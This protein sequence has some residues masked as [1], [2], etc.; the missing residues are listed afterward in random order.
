MYTI[1]SPTTIHIVVSGGGGGNGGGG[2]THNGIIQF[3]ICYDI[4]L[5]KSACSIY[6]MTTTRSGGGGVSD[7][8]TDQCYTLQAQ[9]LPLLFHFDECYVLIICGISLLPLLLLVVAM[10]DNSSSVLDCSFGRCCIASFSFFASVARSVT[11]FSCIC[12]C[13]LLALGV[14]TGV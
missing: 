1:I 12:C 6:T 13:D 14:L 8:S 2:A 4:A 11:R 7:Y 10:F 5:T 9:P 3:V